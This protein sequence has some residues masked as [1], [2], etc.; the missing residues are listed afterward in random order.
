LESSW[1]PDNRLELWG[2]SAGG[3]GVMGGVVI[4]AGSSPFSEEFGSGGGSLGDLIGAGT[5]G[6]GLAS[7]STD[8]SVLPTGVGRMANSAG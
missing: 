4:S 6:D 1:A 2:S 8:T 3:G 5:D 7:T